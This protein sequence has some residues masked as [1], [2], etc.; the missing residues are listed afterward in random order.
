M[1][2]E[3]R[4]PIR[5]EATVEKE[6]PLTIMMVYVKILSLTAIIQPFTIPR[7]DDVSS[8]IATYQSAMTPPT[9]SI[10]TSH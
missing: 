10:P 7:G 2:T 5:K 3:R 1:T 4:N 8:S 9:G 6:K